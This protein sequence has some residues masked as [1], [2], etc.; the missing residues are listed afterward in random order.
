MPPRWRFPHCRLVT[1]IRAID[2]RDDA[3]LQPTTQSLQ[4]QVDLLT[5][6]VRCVI[7]ELSADAAARICGS[8]DRALSANPPRRRLPMSR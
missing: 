4:A 2:T 3:M 5:E 6:V 8:I 1:T 7:A